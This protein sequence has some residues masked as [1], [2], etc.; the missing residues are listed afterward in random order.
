[1]MRSAV[2]VSATVAL[3]LPPAVLEIQTPPSV[4][5]ASDGAGGLDVTVRTNDS[6]DVKDLHI[7]PPEK[8]KGAK[9]DADI[10]VDSLPTGW[11]G[12]PKDRGLS[13]G[14][15]SAG[16]ALPPNSSHTFKLSPGS[17]ATPDPRCSWSVTRDGATTPPKDPHPPFPPEGGPIT[18]GSVINWGKGQPGTPFRIPLKTVN[19]TLPPETEPVTEIALSS[20]DSVE[21]AVY[22]AAEPNVNFR[23]LILETTPRA[24]RLRHVKLD[25]RE[26]TFGFEG[27]PCTD[28]P[29]FVTPDG[30]QLDAEA[31]T[32][33]AVRRYQPLGD[34]T[35]DLVFVVDDNS[36]RR[37]T[38]DDVAGVVEVHE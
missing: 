5:V 22:C 15:G 20:D 30:G 38:A 10:D 27:A 11:T 9:I 32:S 24:L 26:Q 12:R 3:L 4:S 8:P 16:A 33:V 7:L 23:V 21:V 37:F 34:R 18:G 19:L 31:R 17:Q 28:A 13:F 36:D 25:D 14:A 2:V 35:F 1:M 29:F 6:S